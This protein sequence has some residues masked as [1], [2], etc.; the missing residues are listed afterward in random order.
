A[1]VPVAAPGAAHGTGDPQGDERDGDHDRDQHEPDDARVSA[2]TLTAREDAG[3]ELH[4]PRDDAVQEALARVVDGV[5]ELVRG[6]P[7]RGVGVGRDGDVARQREAHAAPAAARARATSR[8]SRRMRTSTYSSA[9]TAA[10]NTVASVSAMTKTT[11]L[12]SSGARS[13]GL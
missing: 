1:A 4:D 7:A 11:E 8:P 2:S 6:P 5:G 3:D 9:M 13:V 12:T 10:R